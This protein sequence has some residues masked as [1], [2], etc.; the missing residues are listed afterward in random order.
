M[1]NI[2]VSVL[3]LI[4]HIFYVALLIYIKPYE[5]SLTIHT[6]GLFTCNIIYLIFLLFINI[7]NFVDDIPDMMT[8][9]FGFL[10]LGAIVVIIGLTIVRLYY[11]YRYGEELEI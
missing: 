2:P 1:A 11:E 10:T 8:L 5:L 6:V 3:A 4:I 9:I 7:I